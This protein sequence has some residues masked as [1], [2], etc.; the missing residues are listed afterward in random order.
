[1]AAVLAAIDSAAASIGLPIRNM[2]TISECGHTGDVDAAIYGM[3]EMLKEMDSMN[4]GSGITADDLC[5]GHPRL[6]QA[7][8]LKYIS[9]TK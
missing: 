6:E 2:H 8:P 9:D 7:D 1:M 4:G 3:F 5:E